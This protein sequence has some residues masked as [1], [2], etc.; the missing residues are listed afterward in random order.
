[1]NKMV[2]M[3]NTLSRAEQNL[4]DVHSDNELVY[5]SGALHQ[6]QMLPLWGYTVTAIALLLIGFFGFFLNLFVIV[7]MCKDIQVSASA[8]E[9]FQC[10]TVK[11]LK[12]YCKSREICS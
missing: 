6:E 4:V 12:I 7:L 9:T 2:L 11:N 5:N 3:T 8:T 10:Q 1:M